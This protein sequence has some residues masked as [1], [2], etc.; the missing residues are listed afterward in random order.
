MFITLRQLQPN[1]KIFR[2]YLFLHENRRELRE[3]K[4]K[5][6]IM[7]GYSFTVVYQITGQAGFP[8]KYFVKTLT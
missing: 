6:F 4:E 3:F 2:F 8:Y 7:T 1:K 5:R